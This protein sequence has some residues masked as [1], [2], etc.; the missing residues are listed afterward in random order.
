M[1]KAVNSRI[2][3]FI[4]TFI[5][6]IWG[7]LSLHAQPQ[8]GAQRPWWY[9]LEQGKHSFRGGDYGSALLSFEDARR[10]RR[11]MYERMEKDFINLLSVSGVRRLGDSLDLVER[12]MQDRHYTAA[13]AALEELFYRYPKES[14]NNSAAAALTAL[15]QLKNYPEAEYWIG[16]TYRAEGELA[17]ALGQFQKAYNQREFFETPGFDI[18]LLYKMAAIRKIRQD[19]NEMEKNLFSIIETDSLW[20]NTAKAEQTRIERAKAEK[21]QA[22]QPMPTGVLPMPYAEASA[23]FASE[24]MTRTLQNEGVNRFLTL[25][26][27]NN[28][29]VEEAHRLLGLY[30]AVSGRHSKAQEHLMFAFLIQNSIIIQEVIRREYDFT[31]TGLAALAEEINR[32]PLIASYAEKSEYYKT[33][34]YLGSSLYGNGK[35]A[36]AREFWAFLA[37]RSEAGEWSNRAAVQLRSPHMEPIVEMP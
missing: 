30:Y 19:Y 15:G 26:R 11:A 5:F 3:T 27:Y 10:Q 28:A 8:A 31:F 6:F 16:E 17:L 9:T 34:Y 36:A 21:D 13:A 4:I 18:A 32:S 7:G 35:G 1:R 29:S 24:A 33:I 37:A 22:G 23:S 20:L 12:Y 25:Y 2:V 14:F